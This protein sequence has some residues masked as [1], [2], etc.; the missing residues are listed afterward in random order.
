MFGWL[1]GV[2]TTGKVLLVGA[3][4]FL[5]LVVFSAWR[6]EA[7]DEGRNEVIVETQEEVIADVKAANEA[8]AEV[9]TRSDDQRV[10]DCKLRSRTPELCE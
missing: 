6:D 8:R 2:T 3:F 4:L 10:A 5:L 9:V 1:K 7:K